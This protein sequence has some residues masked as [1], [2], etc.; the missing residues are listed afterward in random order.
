MKKK[1]LISTGGSG[2]HLIPATILYSHLLKKKDVFIS[3]IFPHFKNLLN[4]CG[5]DHISLGSDID[6]API[7]DFPREIRKPSDF[8]KI[9]DMLKKNKIKSKIIDKFLGQN[10][11]RVLNENLKDK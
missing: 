3:D 9:S 8:E 7:N 11:L 6:G 4:I 5:E 2:G 1:I 10:I